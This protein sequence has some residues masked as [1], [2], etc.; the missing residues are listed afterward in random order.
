MSRDRTVIIG[1]GI[2]GLCAAYH[3]AR[4]GKAV[5]VLDRDPVWEGASGGNAGI[6][7]AGHMPLALPGLAL[8]A[9]KW[10]FDRD[11]PLY[12][13]PRLDLPMFRWFWE[14]H[15]ACNQATLDQS[16]ETLTPLGFLAMEEWGAMM[17]E[18]EAPCD[19]RSN[20]WMNVYRSDHGKRE[21]ED[22]GEVMVRMGFGVESLDG[23]ALLD[24]EPVFTDEVRGAVRFTDSA[25]LDPV[26]FM[27]SLAAKLVNLGVEINT[28]VEVT[29]LVI[30]AGK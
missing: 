4:R 27:K 20:G 29:S 2:T 1:G 21:A 15:R 24:R 25:S 7:A 5:M 9:A 13:P 19:F 28:G 3:L 12:I 23:P 10:M 6:L 11:S 30:S 16:M 26:A 22:E 8:K 18:I 17:E 14:F